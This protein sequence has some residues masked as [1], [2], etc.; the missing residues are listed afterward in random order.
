L[1]D[2]RGLRFGSFGDHHIQQF[3]KI[4]FYLIFKII[5]DNH[6]GF[7]GAR[8]DHF[9]IIFIPK[10]LQDPLIIIQITQKS[11]ENHPITANHWLICREVRLAP[12]ELPTFPGVPQAAAVSPLPTMPG[13]ALSAGLQAPVEAQAAAELLKEIVGGLGWDGDFWDDF[14]V[15]SWLSLG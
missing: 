11:P 1:Y 8:M 13:F 7:W 2:F 15:E 9:C 12:L 4:Q 14:L 6:I 10:I 3:S 5:Q